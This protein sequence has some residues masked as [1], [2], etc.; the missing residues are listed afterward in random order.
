MVKILDCTIRDGGYV[1]AWD[2]KVDVVREVYRSLSKAG[3][4]YMEIGYRG[5]VKY[6]A[7]DKFGK[8]RYSLDENI[9]KVVDGIDGTEIALMVD[10]GKF[11]LDELADVDK[12]KVSLIRVAAHKND[13]KGALE[14]CDRIKEK[15]Y[16]TAFNAMA[17][18]GY[19]EDEAQNLFDIVASHSLDYFTV[20]DSYGSMFPEKAGEYIRMFKKLDNVQIG[21]HP[22]NNLQMA[23]AN[24]IQA[25]K[26]GVD[27]VDSTI[28]GIGRGAGNL[29]TEILISYMIANNYVEHLNNIPV[30]NIID[31]Y[32]LSLMAKNPWGYRLQY[33]IS[34]IFD[35]HPSY[36]MNM[37][38]KREY[39]MEDIWQV[40]E[41][42]NKIRPTGFD[43]KILDKIIRN[44]IV[45]SVTPV[46][47]H[48]SIVD[49]VD[50]NT[51]VP[52][53]NRH[54]G[55]D[56][57]ILA[58][59]PTLKEKRD[60][61]Q[62]FI[63]KYNPI[64]MGANYLSDL[65]EP[66]YHAF[67]NKNRFKM[68][69]NMISAKSKVLIGENITSEMV[70]EYLAKDYEYLCFVD[71]V[72]NPFGIVN[73]RIQTSCRTIS[74]LLMGV[75]VVMGAK[76][77]FSAGMD[78]YIV[79]KELGKYLFYDEVFDTVDMDIKLEIH[80]WNE[81]FMKQIDEYIKSI[82]GE[83][84]HIITPTSYKSFYKSINN[85]L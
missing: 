29:P 21:F 26:N 11:D 45:G 41:L 52:Y 69:A 76:R 1:N 48:K 18:T 34:G 31:T 56:F 61:I 17:L 2:F 15:G 37:I 36:S 39:S 49:G 74:V 67:V 24:T 77:I 71:S 3:I 5:S 13:I 50:N 19:S 63:D 27:M 73:G 59:G 38:K 51:S 25:I 83:G 10:Y 7:P 72:N 62:A 68:Y 82:G 60:E 57:L 32:F 14:L 23:F 4:D 55:R 78:G 35:S 47:T 42:V 20:V 8:W 40:L 43:Q 75:A 64:V 53:V 16:K 6:F 44:G 54:K 9:A 85:Y 80:R 46:S 22:H 84:I 30:L 70:R 12:C 81:H 65:F 33:M 58:N 66:D 79:T 28:Y